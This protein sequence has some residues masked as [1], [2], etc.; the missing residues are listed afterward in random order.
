MKLTVMTA[1]EQI[2]SLDVDPD[3]SVSLPSTPPSSTSPHLDLDGQ[4][5]EAAPPG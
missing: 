4:Q 3:E 5:T 1:D 2:L